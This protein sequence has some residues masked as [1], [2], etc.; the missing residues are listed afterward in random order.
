MVIEVITAQEFFK[1]RENKGIENTPGIYS[2]IIRIVLVE[3]YMKV[4]LTPDKKLK[5]FSLFLD[6][7]LTIPYGK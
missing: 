6:E 1:E 7:E 4:I 5:D 3:L 2:V